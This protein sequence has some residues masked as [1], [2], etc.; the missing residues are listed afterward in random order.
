M[1]NLDGGLSFT[2]ITHKL[3][4]H[5]VGVF[6]VFYYIF[7]YLFKDYDVTTLKTIHPF[8]FWNYTKHPIKVLQNKNN[9]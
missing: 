9:M 2:F 1:K 4:E 5:F 6:T 7:K 3:W 8:T